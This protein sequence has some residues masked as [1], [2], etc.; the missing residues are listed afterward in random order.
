MADMTGEGDDRGV[1][2]LGRCWERARRTTPSAILL[3]YAR[4][5]N[6][7]RSIRTRLWARN[8]PNCDTEA[9]AVPHS[10]QIHTPLSMA[11]PPYTP[12]LA[13]RPRTSKAEEDV[14]SPMTLPQLI[15]GL[16]A[17]VVASLASSYGLSGL[18]STSI[19]LLVLYLP[20]YIDGAQYRFS[21]T[22][23]SRYWATFV[24]SRVWT[25]LFSYFPASIVCSEYDFAANAD[26]DDALPSSSR[27]N[28]NAAGRGHGGAQFVFGVHPHGMMSLNHFLIFTDCVGFISKIAPLTRRDLGASIVFYVPL[29]REICLWAGVVDASAKTAHAVL[30]S[31][32]SIQLYPGGIAEQI[33]TDSNQPIAVAKGRNGFV[34]LALS[35][36][37][38]RQ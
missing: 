38:P 20:F 12:S 1:R 4:R 11:P 29:L 19:G 18:T 22:K 17:G 3:Y 9:H 25:W 34:K 15:G 27:A 35:Y 6:K 8:S 5:P 30:A 21:A 36:D 7:Y 13:S 31:G 10:I 37:L 14:K 23:G 16:L 28:I 26:G 24:R 33:R 32:A 2:P